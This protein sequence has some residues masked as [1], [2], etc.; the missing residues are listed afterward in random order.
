M[1][2]VSRLI[3]SFNPEPQATASPESVACGS[4]L[5]KT[6]DCANLIY[7][8]SPVSISTMPT[9]D[10]VAARRAA[11][12]RKRLLQMHFESGVGH[13]GGNL[14]CL[15]ILLALYHDV[16]TD[17]DQFVLSKGHAAGALYTALW[18][19]GRL[20]DSDLKTFHRD[21]TLLSGHPPARGIADIPFATGSLGHGVGLAAGLA[22]GQRLNETAGRVI[23]LT[24]DGEWN[25]GSTWESLIFSKHH[26]LANLVVIVDQN[27][28]QGFGTT[29]DV[30]DLS[31]LADKFRA[32]GLMTVE[33]DGHDQAAL[34]R[35]LNSTNF[36]GPL[37][38]VAKTIK[39][40]GV[41][42]MEN[43]LEWH[44]LP[45]TAEQYEQA[46]LEVAHP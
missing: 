37:M 6:A 9:I 26:Q 33:L 13:I 20:S 14:S 34:T 18:S 27:G 5:N 35:V 43:R 40:H 2:R 42:F 15:D 17:I 23:C 10:S 12:A 29:S 32:F 4:G 7:R 3:E 16:L 39:G 41:S 36:P 8:C 24:S 31:P 45:M 1:N 25:E 19:V 11:S 44:Y 28:L 30:A 22:L 38:I 21:D 46:C